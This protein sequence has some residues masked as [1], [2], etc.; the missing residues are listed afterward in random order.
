M[1]QKQV[2]AYKRVEK[3]FSVGES[4]TVKD[5]FA[6]CGEPTNTAQ[7]RWL[8]SYGILSETKKGGKAI[9]T[10]V[11]K[12]EED[13]FEVAEQKNV[14][15]TL[16]NAAEIKN[17]E[18]YTTYEMAEAELKHY[19]PF[20][21]DK[22]IL[23]NCNDY[24]HRG[25]V[26]YLEDHYDE[27]GINEIICTEYAEHGKV[28]IFRGNSIM[29]YRLQGDGSF[30]SEEVVNLLRQ[31]DLVVTNPPFSMWSEMIEL[32]ER[33]HKDFI[34]IESYLMGTYNSILA[35]IVARKILIGFTKPEFFEFN[36]D[37]ATKIKNLTRHNGKLTQ[38]ANALWYTNLPINK[39]SK[40]LN[41][42]MKYSDS[43]Y[44]KYDG[45]NII[46]CASMSQIP[47]DYYGEI[48]VPYNYIENEDYEHFDLL[49]I[50]KNL[51]I[52][53]QSQFGKCI[54]RRKN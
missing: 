31:C 15:D 9:F 19:I 3:Y 6:R 21:K 2:D 34:I 30:L 50:E 54:I 42:Y 41:C 53:G 25:I 51:T 45:T 4:F 1:T 44:Q 43:K 29:E 46:N 39:P 52:K 26:Q 24:A 49:R 48:G 23:L 16:V 47:V 38:R 37:Q 12:I 28:R 32:L 22:K 8:V 13:E 11:R 5:L 33:E 7:L 35:K 18:F 20:F 14:R 36:H 10:F 40:T 17:D 27:F